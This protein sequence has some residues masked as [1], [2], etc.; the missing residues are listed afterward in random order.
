MNKSPAR[1]ARRHYPQIVKTFLF[2]KKDVLELNDHLA[3]G[4]R[5][6]DIISK[7]RALRGVHYL[8]GTTD[9]KAEIPEKYLRYQREMEEKW[10]AEQANRDSF[11]MMIDMQAGKFPEQGSVSDGL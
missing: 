9:T 4:W 1:I 2:P 11:Q 10:Q 7:H 5:L 3:A 8:L 6:V